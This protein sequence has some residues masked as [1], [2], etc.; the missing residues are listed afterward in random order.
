MKQISR[1]RSIYV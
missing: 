1:N